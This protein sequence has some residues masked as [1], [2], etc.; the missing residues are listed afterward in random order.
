MTGGSGSAIDRTAGFAREAY[1]INGIRTVVLSIGRVLV[2][3]PAD[4]ARKLQLV[5]ATGD[6]LMLINRRGTLQF[7]ALPAASDAE[8]TPGTGLKN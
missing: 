5:S 8:S 1:D 2:G 6:V 4:A 3:S 7:M